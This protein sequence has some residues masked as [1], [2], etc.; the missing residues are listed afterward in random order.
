MPPKSKKT[1][2]EEA[3]DFLSSLDNLDAPP[4]GIE[5][6]P[7]TSAPIAAGELPRASTDS[8]RPK[9]IK[10][11][12]DLSNSVDLGRSKTATPPPP[13]VEAENDEANEALAFLQA[14]I[15]T[16]R[17][18]LSAPKPSAPRAATP[19]SSSATAAAPSSSSSATLASAPVNVPTASAASGAS[20]GW[21]SSWWSSATSALQNAQKIADEGYKRVRTEGVAGVSEQLKGVDLNKLRQGAEERLGGIVKGVDLEK[22]REDL[23][24]HTSST[25]TT[26]LDTVAPP[27][28]AHET[29]ELWLAHPMSGYAGVEG[30][31]YRAWTKIL[32]QTESG[33]LIVMWSAE[34]PAQEDM[35]R[36]MNPVEGFETGWKRQNEQIVKVREREEENPQGRARANPSVPVT[37]VPIFLHLQPVLAPLS[38]P[39]PPILLSQSKSEPGS[40]PT[41]PKHLYFLMTLQDPSHS[42]RF[43][44]VSQ[45]APADWLD[46]EYEKSDWVE[47]RLVEVLR[48]GVEIIAQDYVATRMGMK[49]S[50]ATPATPTEPKET[51]A[52]P[53]ETSQEDKKA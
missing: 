24:K 43:T 48:N 7:S 26:I 40:A 10:S 22:L 21:G 25:L 2:A 52:A 39:E 13:V 6:A 41:P 31:V 11:S 12:T 42:L 5:T 47:E 44:T 32:E 46:V 20:S 8:A 16:K 36:N 17:A 28:A 19:Q 33:E 30:V 9:S 27:I 38:I 14:Q 53:A 37:T 23:L 34:D 3:A 49:P 4:A 15:N 50:I 51:S 29:L 35:E 1:K 45:P 18:P